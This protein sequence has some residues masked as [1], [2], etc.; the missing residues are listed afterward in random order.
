MRQ[1]HTSRVG[2]RNGLER[3]EFDF[4]GLDM[5]RELALAKGLAD[6]ARLLPLDEPR[7]EVYAN[8]DEPLDAPR[9]HATTPSWCHV[10]AGRRYVSRMRLLPGGYGRRSAW[11][12][13]R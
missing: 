9:D 6:H 7:G 13:P 10:L 2:A 4:P 12:L 11:P 3:G 1:V 8:R 5:P